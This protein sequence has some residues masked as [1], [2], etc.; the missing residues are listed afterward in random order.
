MKLAFYFVFQVDQVC[1]YH[2]VLGS[3]EIKL[4]RQNIVRVLMWYG[5]LNQTPYRLS[6]TGWKIASEEIHV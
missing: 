5:S 2:I 6:T 1:Y 3:D 4:A